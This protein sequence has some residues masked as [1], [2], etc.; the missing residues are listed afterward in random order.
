[1]QLNQIYYIL[2]IYLAKPG[3][4]HR[5]KGMS[6]CS[7]RDAAN[8]RTNDLLCLYLKNKTN[9]TIRMKRVACV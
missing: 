2:I 9:K 8:K 1:V 4:I 5:T 3:L 6:R 7:I